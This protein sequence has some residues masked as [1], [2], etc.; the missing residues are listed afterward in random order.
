M[1][2]KQLSC[3]SYLITEIITLCFILENTESNMNKAHLLSPNR[4][5][6]KTEKETSSIEP[7]TSTA[8]LAK[9]LGMYIFLLLLKPFIKKKQY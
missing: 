8:K 9:I 2:K 5:A 6:H 3:A 7:S 4:N 1:A